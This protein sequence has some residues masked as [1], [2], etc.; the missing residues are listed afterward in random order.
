MVDKLTM[1][2]QQPTSARPLVTIGMPV[3]N[4]EQLLA[5]ALESAL[6][7]DY[8]PLEVVLCDNASTDATEQIA[9]RFASADPRVRYIRNGTDVGPQNNFRLAIH[10]A[11]GKYFTWLAHDDVLSDR[12]C[13]SLMVEHLEQHPDVVVCASA[14][15][16]LDFEGTGSRTVRELPEIAPHAPWIDARK[17]FFRWP[18]TN[19]C[20]A[21]Y[22]LFR[23]EAALRTSLAR[24]SSVS[25]DPRIAT[26]WVTTFLAELCV[27]AHRGTPPVPP[28]LSPGQ[29]VLGAAVVPERV[30]V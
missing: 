10:E 8:A 7:Q 1:P 3:Y 2:E 17:E 28:Q 13:I 5:E 6:G 11:Q 20:Y 30:A 22:G 23:R 21:V 9:N 25:S 4:G 24:R 19:A 15:A 26:F 14:F 16:M 12:R 27:R 18:Q 29:R